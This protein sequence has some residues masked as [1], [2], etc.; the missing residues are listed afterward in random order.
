M[1]ASQCHALLRIFS[2]S[3]KRVSN[4]F[5]FAAAKRQPVYGG[6]DASMLSRSFAELA[7]W[8]KQPE[9]CNSCPTGSKHRRRRVGP[10]SY[11]AA[12]GLGFSPSRNSSTGSFMVDNVGQ[13]W[14]LSPCAHTNVCFQTS[15]NC[16]LTL[17]GTWSKSATEALRTCVHEPHFKP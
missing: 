13:C 6:T 14:R 10:K 9:G 11:R 16:P 12:G 8:A 5:T 15:I 1:L 4:I 3:H 2:L 17:L 7:Q